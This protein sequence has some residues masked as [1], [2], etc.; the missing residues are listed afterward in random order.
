MDNSLSSKFEAIYDDLATVCARLQDMDIYT[1][2]K[3][4]DRM[5]D[6]LVGM[7][8][9]IEDLKDFEYVIAEERNEI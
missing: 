3:L 6:A 4:I 1:T 8:G 9:A 5:Y 7:E 2:R